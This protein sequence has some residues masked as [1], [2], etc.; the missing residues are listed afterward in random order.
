[1]NTDTSGSTESIKAEALNSAALARRHML[2]KGL[3]KGT[4]VLAASVPLQTLASQSVFTYDG[5]GTATQIRCGVSGM[6]SGIHS[7]DV[8]TNQCYGFSPGYYHKREH[9]PKS[10]NADALITVV[11]PTCNLLVGVCTTNGNK[12]ACKKNDVPDSTKVPSLLEVMNMT[13]RPDEFHWL[14]AWLNAQPDSPAVQYPYT[15][16]E[17]QAFYASKDASA[18]EFI[19]KYMENHPGTQ[20]P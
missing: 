10:T 19:K 18:F 4:A 5:P 11:F 15:G 8:T 6:T 7:R 3:G 17:I 13:P 14:A 1:M 16:A 2:L 9:F 12:T 20:Y